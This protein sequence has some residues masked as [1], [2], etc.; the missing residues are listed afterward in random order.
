MALPATQ[1]DFEADARARPA[2]YA[3]GGT[4]LQDRPFQTMQNGATIA[5]L[6]TASLYKFASEGRL[7]LKRLGGRTLVETGSLIA[8]MD[9]AEDW[10]PSDRTGKA[11][12]KRIEQSRAGWADAS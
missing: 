12:A 3:N 10:V 5:G 1:N 11:V 2:S 4:P 9:A 6:S 7:I 8:L